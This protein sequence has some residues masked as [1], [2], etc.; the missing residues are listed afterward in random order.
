MKCPVCNSYDIKN[1]RE[2]NSSKIKDSY[3]YSDIKLLKCNNCCHVFNEITDIN[4]LIN[5]YKYEYIDSKFSMPHNKENDFLGIDNIPEVIS[6]NDISNYV[7]NLI[8]FNEGRYN[9]TPS[10][11]I[12]DQFLEHCWDLKTVIENIKKALENGEQ[13]Y[14]SVPDYD[15]YYSAPFIDYFFLIKE[16][17]NHFTEKNI[18]YLFEKNNFKLIKKKKSK[19]ELMNGKTKMPNMEFLF[20]N[21]NKIPIENGTFCYGISREFF[22]LIGNNK[23]KNITG[24]IDDTPDKIGKEVDGIEIYSNEIINVLSEKSKIIITSFFYKNEIF[25]KLKKNNYKG[26]IIFL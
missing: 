18:I 7:T 26:E 2:I 10:S 4:S 16:H 5:Y 11:L 14:I 6:Q 19:L 3:L 22:Y 9:H 15:R 17:I 12:L 25:K 1:Q 8:N 23:I 24:L 20:V 13:L 21:E